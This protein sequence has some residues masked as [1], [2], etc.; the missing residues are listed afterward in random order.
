MYAKEGWHIKQ[1]FHFLKYFGH[2][3]MLPL[4]RNKRRRYTPGKPIN[5][6]LSF[7]VNLLREKNNR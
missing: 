5:F 3:H 6:R 7:G 1:V 2:E 4:S